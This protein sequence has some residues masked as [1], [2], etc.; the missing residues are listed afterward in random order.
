MQGLLLLKCSA[1]VLR[2]LQVWIGIR[3]C[4]MGTHMEKHHLHTD[5]LPLAEKRH[6]ECERGAAVLQWVGWIKDYDGGTLMECVINPKLPYTDF[7][8]LVERQREALDRHIR[9]LSRSHVV[10]PGLTS[11]AADGHHY[12]SVSSIPG[13]CGRQLPQHAWHAVLALRDALL[14]RRLVNM[15]CTLIPAQKYMMCCPPFMDIVT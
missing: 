13:V 2:L 15:H 6:D 7:P 14:L 3:L 11:F 4:R 10:H 1:M 8:T 9:T 12:P 5:Y